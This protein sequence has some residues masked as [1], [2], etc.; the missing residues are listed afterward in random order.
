MSER[1]TEAARQLQLVAAAT[2]HDLTKAAIALVDDGYMAEAERLAEAIGAIEALQLR[3]H[4]FIEQLR[5]GHG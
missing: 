1:T 4:T 5:S 3:I 2:Q